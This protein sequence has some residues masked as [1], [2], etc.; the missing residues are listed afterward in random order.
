MR[1]RKNRREEREGERGG[2]ENEGGSEEIERE[3]DG[4]KGGGNRSEK[5][6]QQNGPVDT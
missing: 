3:R 6:K 1:V 5:I 2:N 4:E